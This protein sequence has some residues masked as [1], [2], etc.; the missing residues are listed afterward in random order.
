MATALEGTGRSF[1]QRDLRLGASATAAFNRLMREPNLTRI[2]EGTLVCDRRDSCSSS[3][4]H[5]SGL[6]SDPAVSM[7]KRGEHLRRRAPSLRNEKLFQAFE[8]EV[9]LEPQLASQP[10]EGR[11]IVVPRLVRRARGSE[12]GRQPGLESLV[13]DRMKGEAQEMVRLGRHPVD[14]TKDRRSFEN[15]GSLVRRQVGDP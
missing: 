13:V 12:A 14:P 11:G 8:A 1:D 5:L 9:D 2:P 15:S 10:L 3:G 7:P 4:T 6:S